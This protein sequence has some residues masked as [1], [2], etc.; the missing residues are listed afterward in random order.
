MGSK[1]RRLV[2]E[3]SITTYESYWGPKPTISLLA[4]SRVSITVLHT[5]IHGILDHLIDIMHSI[6]II[7]L[8]QSKPTM[9]Q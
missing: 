5:F 4:K 7:N 3:S 8:F 1:H 2:E 9:H 6:L